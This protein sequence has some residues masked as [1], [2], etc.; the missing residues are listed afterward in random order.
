MKK[1]LLII[2]LFIGLGNVNAQSDATWEETV[3]FLNKYSIHLIEVGEY[4]YD[5]KVRF[6]SNLLV[7]NYKNKYSPMNEAWTD[8]LTYEITIDLY[9]LSEI[10]MKGDNYIQLYTTGNNVLENLD[11]KVWGKRESGW[12]EPFNDSNTPY[13]KKLN[14]YTIYVSDTEMFGR[15]GKAFQHLAKLANEKRENEKKVSGDKF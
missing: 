9:K 1:I 5:S 12:V 3:S 11:T 15:L 14:S 6:S 7:I 2:T 8:Y 4:V 10:R 13:S